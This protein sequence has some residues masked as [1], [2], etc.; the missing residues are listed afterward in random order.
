MCFIKYAKIMFLFVY[1]Y[2]SLSF[3]KVYYK[4]LFKVRYNFRFLFIV[5]ITIS[6]SIN[7]LS[8]HRVDYSTVNPSGISQPSRID[9][10]WYFQIQ[11]LEVKEYNTLYKKYFASQK[12][13]VNKLCSIKRVEE[14]KG[15]GLHKEFVDTIIVDYAFSGNPYNYS[16]PNDNTMAISNDGI[17]VSAVNTNII[18]Y[19]TKKDSLLKKMTLKQFSRSLDGISNHQYD[20]KA[21][22][23]YQYDRFILVYLAGSGTS[24]S[25]HIIVAF[26]TTN[27]P[28]DD[29]NLYAVEG[30]PFD[31]DSWTDYPA[32]AL[33]D[34]ELFITGNLI[35]TGNGSW[36]TSFK[37]SLIWQMDKQKGFDG[38][39]LNMA[40][41]SDINYQD[42][43][44]R[45]I[46]PV[47]GGNKFYGP[48]MYFLSERNFDIAN[49]SFFVM[50]IEKYLED[51]DVNLD[52]D[53]II[54]DEKYGMPPNALQPILTDS[55]ATND[56]RV[57]GAFFY[58]NKIQFVG[59][60]VDVNTG[61]ASFY[62][63]V[64]NLAE[65]KRSI[66]LN[67]FSD[68]V[69]E[70]GYPNISFCGTTAESQQSIITYNYTSY[71]TFPGMAA[72]IF[73]GSDDAYSLPT[74]LKEGECGIKV[75]NGTLQRWGDYSASQPMYNKP[76]QVWTSATYGKKRNSLRVYGTWIASLNTQL[77]DEVDLADGEN[78]ETKVYPNPASSEPV[79]IEFKLEESEVIIVQIVDINGKFLDEI[80]H[81]EAKRGRNRIS[82]LTTQLSN[83]LYFVI[84]KSEEKIIKTHK[85][86][87]VN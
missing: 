53:V 27:N 69:L 65:N 84:I 35:K 62:H 79:I 12:R 32:I 80:Y 52:I 86:S 76:G 77:V 14:Y 83:G 75:L 36:Q 17:V 10:D 68:S 72:F 64:L 15:N 38:E 71:K 78:I 18:F 74:I 33:T 60:S 31:D 5:I 22:Y 41:F 67:V 30:N 73:K 24:G 58:D 42:I 49:D 7:A 61:H 21:I 1:K 28:L 19:D 56:S 44:C 46:H 50:K 59:N 40:I 26:S 43:P 13:K 25:S 81:Q 11:N 48:E 23:D 29:W 4:A 57:L 3:S 82:F 8:Q 45:N 2:I 70:Y 37:Q 9:S 39:E 47:R 6:F 16:A 66:H 87:V 34:K 54:A 85:I 63:G 51:G 55:L 20:P